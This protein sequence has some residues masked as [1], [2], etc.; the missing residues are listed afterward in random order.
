MEQQHSE[1]F[2][3]F[4]DVLNG[5]KA[6]LENHKQ[7]NVEKEEVI[8]ELNQKV[9]VLEQI[10]EEMKKNA[11]KA[12]NEIG[13]RD[14][15]I[16]SLAQQIDV[17]EEQIHVQAVQLH[18]MNNQISAFQSASSADRI[19]QNAVEQRRRQSENEARM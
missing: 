2:G 12:D 11:T 17:K 8:Q 1:E 5:I 13:L 9:T 6:S 16:T 10:I 4:E 3:I 18:Q 19:V 14:E 15:V 7:D